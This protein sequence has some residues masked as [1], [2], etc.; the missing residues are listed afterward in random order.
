[1]LITKEV[2]IFNEPVKI[3]DN[4]CVKEKKLKNNILIFETIFL[5]LLN[6]LQF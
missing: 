6:N 3:E 1:M 5:Y 4:N 2:L